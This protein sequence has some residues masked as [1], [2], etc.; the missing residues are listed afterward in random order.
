MIVLPI[1]TYIPTTSH[2]D[3]DALS[4]PVHRRR[5][6]SLHSPS[7]NMSVPIRPRLCCCGHLRYRNSNP[8][9]AAVLARLTTLLCFSGLVIRPPS[10]VAARVHFTRLGPNSLSSN[11]F[12]NR[13]SPIPIVNI[14]LP[15]ATPVIVPLSLHDF[16]VQFLAGRNGLYQRRVLSYTSPHP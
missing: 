6:L 10:M 2:L 8:Y 16:Q 15:S 1:L 3:V 5:P 14:S 13:R 9:I 4:R 7:F 12:V 11:Q